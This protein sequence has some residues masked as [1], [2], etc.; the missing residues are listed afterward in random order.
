MRDFELSISNLLTGSDRSSEFVLEGRLANLFVTSSRVPDDALIHAQG[1]VEAVGEGM[2]VSLEARTG[3]VGECVRCLGEVT[4]ELLGSSRELFVDGDDTE[5]YYGYRGE[6]L[7]L[8]AAV[9]D[10]CMTVKGSAN[11]VAPTSTMAPV[12]VRVTPAIRDGR[13]S[14]S[15]SRPAVVPGSSRRGSTIARPA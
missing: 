8:T 9:S 15:S 7:D 12:V 2:L 6:V 5:E 4:G 1:R 3:F 11:T 10:L 13:S 14:I